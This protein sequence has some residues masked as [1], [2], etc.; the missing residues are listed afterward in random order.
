MR[1]YPVV[2]FMPCRL[3][4]YTCNSF[5]FSAR[6]EKSG[7]FPAVEAQGA[8]VHSTP[9]CLVASST[10]PPVLL[11][12]F[13]VNCIVE[14]PGITRSSFFPSHTGEGRITFPLSSLDICFPSGVGHQAAESLS[15]VALSLDEFLHAVR[16]PNDLTPS[17]GGSTGSGPTG[18]G[19]KEDS[20][21]RRPIYA[22]K[23]NK[24]AAYCARHR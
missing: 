12:G 7:L 1:I 10:P 16:R 21:E 11:R 5:S 13:M 6:H 9:S 24:K 19:C 23:G 14:W 18:K 15:P 20:C 8:R 4:C 22:Y 3:H 17:A 2:G